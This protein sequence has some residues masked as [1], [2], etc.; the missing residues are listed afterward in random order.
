MSRTDLPRSALDAAAS[1]AREE[2]T[3]VLADPRWERYAAGALDERE[4]AELEALA[5]AAPGAERAPE[6]L[7]PLGADQEARFT[8][9][10]LRALTSL[11]AAAPAERAA[12]VEQV[13]EKGTPADEQARSLPGAAGQSPPAANVVPIT[14]AAERR[15]ARPR[16]ALSRA[17][18]WAAPLA[19]AAALVGVWVVRGRGRGPLP[20]FEMSIS[21]GPRDMRG[22]GDSADPASGFNLGVTPGNTA[23]P[24]PGGELRLTPGAEIRVKLRPEAPVKGQVAAR[25]VLVTGAGAEVLPAQVETSPDGALRVRARV[26]ADA[27][28]SGAPEVWI[29][30][31][32]PAQLP[33]EGPVSSETL[34]AKGARGPQVFRRGAVWG[35]G[36]S[37]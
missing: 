19:L 21:A 13:A 6:L 18:V 23:D 37:P 30:V 12:A 3:D 11:P 24:A 7:R 16:G 31:G 5:A 22:P 8:E 28:V 25:V 14:S 34:S 9:A 15:A 27:P 35:S 2:A 29:L 4:R 36:P 33:P 32:R 10:A 20:A 17:L 1:L 26:P